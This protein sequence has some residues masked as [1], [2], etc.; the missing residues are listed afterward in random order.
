MYMDA[1]SKLEIVHADTE[2]QMYTCFRNNSI[3]PVTVRPYGYSPSGHLDVVCARRL[4]LHET[5]RRTVREI[6]SGQ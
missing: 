5:Y 4:E 1:E 6:L 3:N 2:V